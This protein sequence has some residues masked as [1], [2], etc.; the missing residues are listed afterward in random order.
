MSRSTGTYDRMKEW[1]YERDQ[2]IE[3]QRIAEEQEY[4]KI[5]EAEAKSRANATRGSLPKGF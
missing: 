4:Q 3:Q 5:V 2:R 1:Q